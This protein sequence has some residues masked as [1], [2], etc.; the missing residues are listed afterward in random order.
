ML[1]RVRQV[2]RLTTRFIQCQPRY[3]MADNKWKE[4]EDAAENMY[5]SQKESNTA[6]I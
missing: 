5:I 2:A 1:Q 4:R 6:L 3:S